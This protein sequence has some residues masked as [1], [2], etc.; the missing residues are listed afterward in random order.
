MYL[1]KT[2]CEVQALSL[3]LSLHFLFKSCLLFPYIF[4]WTTSSRPFCHFSHQLLSLSFGS[5][6]SH[7]CQSTPQLAEAQQL[8]QLSVY[9]HLLNWRHQ[10]S[11]VQRLCLAPSFLLST[12]LFFFILHFLLLH[13]RDRSG[14]SFKVNGKAVFPNARFAVHACHSRATLSISPYTLVII[15]FILLPSPLV[16][17]HH[18]FTKWLDTHFITWHLDQRR[19]S[20]DWR[21][22]EMQ[23]FKH[24][25]GDKGWLL[26]SFDSLSGRLSFRERS[27]KIQC[28]ISESLNMEKQTWFKKFYPL[29]LFFHCRQSVPQT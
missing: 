9:S 3:L 16:T 5:F 17:V 20:D 21:K 8:T 28:Q 14:A 12:L 4:W 13:N 1:R 29:W 22:K 25:Q 15:F 6:N 18:L 27:S 10:N 7:T 24:R 19:V 23:F 26:V 11:E 2:W